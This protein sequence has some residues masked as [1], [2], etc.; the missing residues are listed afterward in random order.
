MVPDAQTVVVLDLQVCLV[1]LEIPDQQGQ[2]PPIALEPPCDR[3]LH[4]ELL[5][6]RITEGFAGLLLVVCLRGLLILQRIRV[7]FVGLDD[8]LKGS[9]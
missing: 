1:P 5:E 6:E 7:S 9:F 2:L 3:G 4:R 8:L